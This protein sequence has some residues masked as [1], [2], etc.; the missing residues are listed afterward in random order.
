MPEADVV[1]V[2]D[3]AVV[4][5]AARRAEPLQQAERLAL[6]LVLHQQ[7]P[8]Q[9]QQTRVLDAA[10]VADVVVAAVMPFRRSAVRPLSHGF[11]FCLGPQRSTTT[12]RRTR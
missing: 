6:Q 12:T 2:V 11:H 3:E 7:Q 9:E 5:D 10:A 8:E 4:A 1:A